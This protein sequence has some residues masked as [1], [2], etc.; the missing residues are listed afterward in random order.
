V[1]HI[2]SGH[3]KLYQAYQNANPSERLHILSQREHAYQ[4]KLQSMPYG[5]D[6]TTDPYLDTD[7]Q[8]ECKTSHAV[9]EIRDKKDH[10]VI[11]PIDGLW[12]GFN[13]QKKQEKEQSKDDWDIIKRELN[14][15]QLLLKPSHSHGVIPEKYSVVEGHDGG[16]R[17]QCSNRKLNVSDFG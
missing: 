8:G 13:E 2:N 10:P 1:K 5:K 14:A 16:P 17:I 11:N 7:H 6:L 12:V 4:M 15:Q 9:L 3:K